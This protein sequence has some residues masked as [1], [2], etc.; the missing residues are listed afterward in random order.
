MNSNSSNKNFYEKENTEMKRLNLFESRLFGRICYGFGRDEEGFVYI[1]ENE[2]GDITAYKKCMKWQKEI[3][4]DI[5]Y[6]DLEIYF[7]S[8][9]FFNK[10][11]Y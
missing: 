7:L 2:D 3:Y 1:K 9:K 11:S 6:M 10:K 4:I 8:V 5:I